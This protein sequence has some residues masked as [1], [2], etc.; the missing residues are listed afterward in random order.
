MKLSYPE[1]RPVT[2]GKRA[3]E[4]DTTGTIDGKHVH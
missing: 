1:M 2:H 4:T 3:R